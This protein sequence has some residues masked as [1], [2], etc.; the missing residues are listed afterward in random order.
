[1]KDG[2]EIEYK[3]GLCPTAEEIL[4]TAI[5][6]GISE[7]FTDTDVDEIIHAF[8]KVSAYFQSRK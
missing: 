7:F 2:K 5:R 4:N 3:E 6:F 8:R 1:M